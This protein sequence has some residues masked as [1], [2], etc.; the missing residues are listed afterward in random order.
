MSSVIGLY[1]PG[2]SVLHRLPAGG[3]LAALLAVGVGSVLVRTPP[4]AAA[5]LTVVL[6]GYVVA[7]LPAA[8]LWQSV[9]PLLWVLVPLGVFQVVVAGWQRAVVVVAVMVALVLLAN[10]VT[11]TTRTTDLVDV[12]VRSSR[13]L[14]FLGVDPERLGLVLGLGIRS[15]PLVVDLATEVRDAQHA[16]GRVSSPRAFAVPLIVGALR[17]ADQMGDALAARGFDD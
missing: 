1:R 4:Q 8:L 3:K 6:L 13:R 14:T 7:R 11:L 17:R 16:R 15:V 10:L 12:V 5:L 2:A 9:R